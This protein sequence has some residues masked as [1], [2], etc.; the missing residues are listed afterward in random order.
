M[1]IFLGR[2]EIG[3]EGLDDEADTVNH[4]KTGQ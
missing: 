4:V 1:R 3:Q 2:A